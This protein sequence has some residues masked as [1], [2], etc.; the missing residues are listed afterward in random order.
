[1]VTPADIESVISLT[2]DMVFV[3]LTYDT[4]V[5]LV[6]MLDEVGINYAIVNEWTEEGALQQ[7]EWIKFFAAFL[8]LDTLADEV[9]TANAEYMQELEDLVSEV[10]ADS[11]PKVAYCTVYNGVVYTV[12]G[13]STFAGD[14]ERAG[15]IYAMSDLQGDGVVEV[16]MEEFLSSCRDADIII[17][18]S[19]FCPDKAYLLETEPLFAEFDAFQNDQIFAYS[20]D[21]YMNSAKIVEKYEDLVSICQPSILLDHELVMYIRL[22]DGELQD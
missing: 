3:D 7:M 20:R 21:Y 12:P 5:Q 15:G 8:D 19:R 11:R 16:S 17:Y 9:F 14:I 1:M 22:P 2:P 13:N 6:T 18:G 4:G 10:P